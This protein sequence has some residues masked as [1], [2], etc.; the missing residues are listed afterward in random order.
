VLFETVRATNRFLA[1]NRQLDDAARA[2]L[3][4]VRELF[5]EVGGV[6]GLF[7]SQPGAWLEKIR[8]ARTGGMDITPAE[9][10]G[11]IAE[12]T[13]ARKAKDFRRSDEIRDQLLARGIQLLDSPQGTTWKVK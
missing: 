5:N 7:G 8:S 2:L 6:L 9:I 4:R 12:R 1:E 10:E 13:E 11:L 3:A